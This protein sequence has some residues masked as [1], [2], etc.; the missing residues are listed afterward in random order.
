MRH[1]V[2]T[3]EDLDANRRGP[4]FAGLGQVRGT[5]EGAVGGGIGEQFEQR[6]AG[7]DPTR[8]WVG[9]GIF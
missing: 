9:S 1:D 6:F 5:G 7:H 8:P 3:R 2:P 4:A